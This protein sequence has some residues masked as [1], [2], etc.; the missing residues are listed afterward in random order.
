[1]DA[2]RYIRGSVMEEGAETPTPLPGLDVHLM[3]VASA[4]SRQ[5]A[6]GRTDGDGRFVLDL[7]EM[8]TGGFRWLALRVVDP[9]SGSRLETH[10]VT[11]WPSRVHPG[12]VRV[13]ATLP[14]S[15]AEPSESAPAAPTGGEMRVFGRV[16]HE[17]GT[18]V[19]DVSG[20]RV[21]WLGIDVS[22]ETDADITSEIDENG[23]YQLVPVNTDADFIV[24]LELP[25]EPGFPS[26]VLAVS[27]PQYGRSLPYR[28]DLDVDDDRFRRPSEF[29]RITADT[30]GALGSTAPEEVD[31]RGLALLAGK[32][33]WDIE[34]LGQFAAA[35]RL[36]ATL[37]VDE[38]L[39]YGLLRVG[40]T[41]APRTFLRRAASTAETGLGKAV[42]ANH[43]RVLTS[44]DHSTF[45]AALLA[46][47]KADLDAN[48]DDTLG[49]VLRCGL[50]ATLVTTFID[51]WVDREGSEAEFWA[52]LHGKEGFNDET[53]AQARRLVTL[54]IVG[55]M[56]APA[57][58]SI[59]DELDGDPETSLAA[60][61][62][63]QWASI[64]SS[65][66]LASLPYGLVGE[67]DES[68]RETMARL[69]REHVEELFPSLCSRHRLLAG[70]P[71]E[72]VG[73]EF[74]SAN[75]SFD[76]SLSN[77]TDGAFSGTQAQRRSAAALQRLY[78]VAPVQ[79]RGAVMLALDAAGFQSAQSILRGGRIRFLARLGDGVDPS[80]A[81][82]VYARAARRAA[83]ALTA[84]LQFH[85]RF[86]Q[87]GL[88]FLP[89]D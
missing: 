53:A 46:A 5:L 29:A 41:P 19:T 58:A 57:V 44:G 85:P 75:E 59:L 8:D 32:T 39:V 2:K 64:A 66:R 7:G 68:P 42:A 23:W 83:G 62:D 61:T 37:G 21:R 80:V 78:F 70:L 12:P 20:A 24:R 9:R 6:A 18:R 87:P 28:V 72:H 52:A 13:C 15:C 86:A 55:L 43:V 65:E 49:E 3:G 17:D 48:R 51:E 27:R 82:G 10:G 33:G 47:R 16:R 4:R 1:M 88:A 36:G 45:A 25:G 31:L 38:E 76:L 77:A 14:T 69:M 60:F 35:H 30:A 74:L 79:D 56:F 50:D 89:R 81:A 54:G 67:G 26:E 73:R 34:R 11:R 63:E 84:Y 71:T 40:W 22:G